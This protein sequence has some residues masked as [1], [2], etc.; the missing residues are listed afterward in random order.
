VGRAVGEFLYGDREIFADGTQ[1]QAAHVQ[2][3]TG[4]DA[5]YSRLFPEIRKR[6]MLPVFD[7]DST[8]FL[9]R[10]YR[11]V[12]DLHLDSTVFLS[13][14]L[15]SAKKSVQGLVTIGVLSTALIAKPVSPTFAGARR[16]YH[17]ALALMKMGFGK[18]S[19]SLAFLNPIPPAEWLPAQVGRKVDAF[20]DRFLYHYRTNLEELENYNLDTG[21]FQTE[22]ASH[23]GTIQALGALKREG[24]ALPP[25][26]DK[27]PNMNGQPG[28]VRI[29]A[30]D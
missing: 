26:R 9:A 16:V 15:A 30:Y 7:R 21:E 5:F 1:H 8:G 28:V 27:P 18:D 2:V 25:P 12:Y 14:H 13:S 22:P 24:G 20:A 11:R 4:L 23:L 3:E 10:A 17:R 19:L 29:G 6:R